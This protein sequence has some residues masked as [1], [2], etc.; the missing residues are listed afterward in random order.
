M[1]MGEDEWVDGLGREMDGW[2]RWM[3]GQTDG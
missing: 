3:D 2:M 1:G